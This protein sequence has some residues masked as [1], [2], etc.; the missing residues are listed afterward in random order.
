MRGSTETSQAL[1]DD[2]VIRRLEDI[3]RSLAS[4]WPYGPTPLENRR[5]FREAF[6][7]LSR[8]A[9]LDTYPHLAILFG[10][11][12]RGESA[13]DADVLVIVGG[14]HIPQGYWRISG[15]EGTVDLNVASET[16]L[17]E[18]W[19]DPEWGYCLAEGYAL[20]SNEPRLERGWSDSVRKYWTPA[21]FR[22]RIQS[23]RAAAVS[24]R[25]A[26]DVAAGQRA[27]LVERLLRH[28]AV[29][30]A[31]CALIERFG[32][33]VYSHRSFLGEIWHSGGRAGL[34]PATLAAIVAGLTNV[35]PTPRRDAR[36]DYVRVRSC[37]SSVLRPRILGSR[38]VEAGTQRLRPFG[39]DRRVAE[40]A[41]IAVSTAL[42]EL[43][44]RLAEV[45][46][47]DALP[48]LSRLRTAEDATAMVL[49]AAA[50]SL[51]TRGR[52]TPT[53]AA[54]ELT[55]PT[56]E[57]VDGA[58]WVEYAGDRLKV[59]LSTGGCKT[60]TCRFCTL[61][62][63]GRRDAR[64]AKTLDALLARFRPRE[65]AV[66]N[67]G[68]L[69]N[70]DEIPLDE[71]FE[72]CDVVRNHAVKRLS[73]ESIPRFVRGDVVRRVATTS[74]VADLCVG[75]GLQCADNRVAMLGLGRPDSTAAFDRAVDVLHEAGA[76]IRLYLLWGYG[77]L[78]GPDAPRLLT[79]SVRW[80][81]AR[82][83]EVVTICPYVSPSVATS[84]VAGRSLCVLR[85]LLATFDVEPPCLLT[86]ALPETPSCGVEYGVAGCPACQSS[87][88]MRRWRDGPACSSKLI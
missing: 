81:L 61:P 78:A 52:P 41:S 38:L 68:S 76:Q 87:L 3:G 63:Y 54:P 62:R 21:A 2:D 1:V 72:I 48:A 55:I 5:C 58:R 45:G 23:H 75:M 74:G 18:A 15:V 42:G 20:S 40:L 28:E 10:S 60:P 56:R 83:S 11:L 17:A 86:V 51:P 19:R 35:R 30:S 85:R 14:G 22:Q 46:A 66:Y 64:P 53:A 13:Q 29:R 79:T 39:R 16:W 25:E 88:R 43:E 36:A 57:A 26:A 6:A 50:D 12:A 84:V 67:D 49:D 77:A 73:I 27:P 31:C 8:R 71:L 34:P 37:I 32:T 59:I 4:R 33:R 44:D 70:P 24:L 9:D 47:E 69:L 65:L 7:E 82:R 80:A